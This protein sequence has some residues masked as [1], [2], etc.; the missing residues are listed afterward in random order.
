MRHSIWTML[1]LAITAGASMA[2]R[3][4][5]QDSKG[6][7]TEESI[8]S[9]RQRAE[10]GDADA[11][12]RLGKMYS[13]GT[14]VARDEVEGTR[15]Y[16]KA[17]EQGDIMGEFQTASA[18]MQGRGVARDPAEAAHWLFRVA[19]QA[20]FL[21]GDVDTTLESAV[22]SVLTG[23]Y[24]GGTGVG[25]DTVRAVMW[26]AIATARAKDKNQVRLPLLHATPEQ[27]TEGGRLAKTWIQAVRG[28]AKAQTDLGLV[29]SA[30]KGAAH[31]YEE[32]ARWF[33][34]AADQGDAQAQYALALAYS[35]GEGVPH[36][37]ADAVRWLR[38]AADQGHC[39][40]QSYLGLSYYTGKG[41]ARD[42]VQAL[43]WGFIAA[44]KCTGDDK[45]QVDDF[46]E[47]VGSKVT[48]AQRDEAG[49]RAKAWKPREEE[50][51]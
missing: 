13:E 20:E 48:P 40:A 24:A 29:Y 17:A 33:K 30:E 6:P 3:C 27:M 47:L 41:L 14:G 31:D 35:S 8:E 45:K 16:R 19:E 49:R 26:G 38:R 25:Q 12:S 37:D 1:V 34:R 23:L 39:T 46:V 5:A 21:A 42:N 15:W 22:A 4:Y 28:D 11:Q 18:Y 10:K 44:S 36:D 43:T 9:L 50:K 2:P 51:R 7:A 32:A